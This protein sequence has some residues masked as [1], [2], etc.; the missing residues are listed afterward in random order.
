MFL[1]ILS[2]DVLGCLGKDRLEHKRSAVRLQTLVSVCEYVQAFKRATPTVYHECVCIYSRAH[3]SELVTHNAVFPGRC[4][5]LVLV[6]PDAL[7]ATDVY[8]ARA[9]ASPRRLSR[10]EDRWKMGKENP[11]PPPAQG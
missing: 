7:C 2:V 4:C 10:Y 9:S 11:P 6:M 3:Y 5:L 1:E 8:R